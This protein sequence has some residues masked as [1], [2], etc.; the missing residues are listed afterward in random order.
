MIWSDLFASDV[1]K[2]A[3]ALDRRPRLAAA[4]AMAKSAKCCV[5]AS[6]LGGFPATL[7]S[8]RA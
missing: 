1:E 2:G 4:L 3:D 8:F 7:P 6:K 5:V